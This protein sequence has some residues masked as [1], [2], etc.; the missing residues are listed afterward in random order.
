M[1]LIFISFLFTIA[2]SSCAQRVTSKTI[3]I[4]PHL[5][6]QNYE[7]FKRL[8]LKSPDSPIEYLNNFEF[9]WG[10]SYKLSVKETKLAETLSDGTQF[11]YQLIK[12]LSKTK[13]P[14]STEFKLLLDPNR[15]YYKLDSSEQQMNMTFTPINDS[16]FLYM[17]E[18]EIEV[19][20]EFKDQFNTIVSGGASKLGTF[21][22]MD[23][24]RIRLV[25][26]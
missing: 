5:S 12:V 26:L 23:D 20:G 22:Y 9:D 24:K 10:Y 17:E 21:V 6:F 2:F 25:G 4:D 7:H 15:Y 1:K 13:V 3:T 18:V 14:D 8:T 11:E 19:P 16:V